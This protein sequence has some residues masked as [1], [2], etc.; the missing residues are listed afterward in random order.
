MGERD[1]V[2]TGSGADTEYTDEQLA[3]IRCD[4]RDILVEAAAGSGKTSTTMGR[5]LRLLN[6]GTPAG[7]ILVFTFTDKAAHDLRGKVRSLLETGADPDSDG[8]GIHR[9]SMSEAWV[10]TFH[11]ICASILRSHPIQADLDP[12]FDILDDLRAERIK[13]LAWEQALREFIADP[14]RERLAAR[15]SQPNLKSSFTAAY[16]QLRSLG[17]LSPVLPAPVRLD[18]AVA[19]RDLIDDAAAVQKDPPA[20]LNEGLKQQVADLL[21]FL[22]SRDPGEITFADFQRARLTSQSKLIPEV[23]A[24]MDRVASALASAEF[25][26][27]ALDDFGQLLKLYG[28]SFTELKRTE[29]LLDYEDLQL[30]TLELLESEGRVRSIFRGRFDEIMVDEFQDTNQLQLDLIECFRDEQTR[31]FTVGD[32]MQAIYGFRHADVTLFRSRRR[33]ESGAVRTLPLTA[34]FRSQAEVIGAVNEIG[35]SLDR[36]VGS[37]RGVETGHSLE[38]L[39]VG[40]EPESGSGSGVVLEF[41][42]ESGWAE[43]DLGPIWPGVEP[44]H[45]DFRKGAGNPEAEA[46]GM[47]QRLKAEFDD[48]RER[49][50][51]R[52]TPANTA[53]L[54]RTRS[55]L[56][57]WAEALRQVGIEPYIVGGTGFWESREGTDLRGLLAAIANPRDD[58]SLIAALA[59]PAC[60]LSSDALLRLRQIS[61]RYEPLWPALSR[62]AAIADG[63]GGQIEPG[64]QAGDLAD[65]DPADLERAARFVG[66]VDG[67]RAQSAITPLGETVERAISETGYDLISLLREPSA[68]GMANLHRIVA[69]AAEYESAAGRDL[70]GFLEEVELS[71]R[72]DSEA[73]VATEEEESDV[74]RLMT[75]HKA[76]G[77]QFE[78][79]GVADLGRGVVH[80][81]DPVFRI[82]MVADDSGSG[83]RLGIRLPLENGDSADLFDWIDLDRMG[84]L[85]T[86]DEE[87]RI[88]HVAM[89]R[90]KCRLFLSGSIN[91]GRDLGKDGFPT[92]STGM[93]GLLQ[94]AYA[95]GTDQPPS[96]PVPAPAA[97]PSIDPKPTGSEIGVDRNIAGQDRLSQLRQTGE[98]D[99]DETATGAGPPPLGRP[100]RP[101][102]QAVPLSFSAL[103]EYE[104]CPAQFY[105]RRVLRFG[106]PGGRPPEGDEPT[107]LDVAIIRGEDPQRTSSAPEGRRRKPRSDGTAFG[108]AVHELLEQAARSDWVVPGTEQIRRSL[109]ANDAAEL[110]DR[111][112]DDA[113]DMLT[114]FL[115]S[116][117][118]REV[119]RLQTRPEIP[120]LVQVG[121]AMIEGKADLLATGPEPPL[122]I[123]YKTNRL[124]GQTIEAASDPY[125]LQRDVYAVAVGRA[126]ESDVVRSAYV[127]LER[128]DEPQLEL[129]EAGELASA[130]ER[131]LDLVDGI[132]NA[133]FFG[134]DDAAVQ[135]CGDCWACGMLATQ[136]ARAA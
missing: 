64:D 124:D 99:G 38:P 25:G 15:F 80:D 108:N 52:I 22:R 50:D 56:A 1:P 3:A 132:Q 128:P 82:G 24:G 42:S 115:E 9:T 8:S 63:D 78:V 18:P 35:R 60:G 96:I 97:L 6:D 46:L 5:Y 28:N 13:G 119:S 123:D 84:R 102:G 33:S 89:T 110:R 94:S 76:K 65:F 67:L 112:V 127:F 44:E 61:A 27:R 131:I 62:I 4:D 26:D 109:R 37:M 100:G 71:A 101:A 66:T 12:T 98:R 113:R 86:L 41:T 39:R 79:V 114:G 126:L 43:K 133:R 11:A 88:L 47:A 17:D 106:D 51:S 7:R 91:L 69:M 31:L 111:G 48:A 90:A 130:A 36:E 2:A 23:R 55:K 20:R 134:G 85:D 87:L 70:R 92:D 120:L 103:V 107:G 105:A 40:R 29:N 53:I 21:G 59:G 68:E 93:A 54:F 49:G 74:V 34:N 73:A 129:L 81:S 116:D 83:L 72:L 136:R 58:A 10:G 16:D 45:P 75:I 122:F 121:G 14:D 135:P 104:R 19:I 117:L 57:V 118:G 77:L 30:R 95:I 125:R 32:E